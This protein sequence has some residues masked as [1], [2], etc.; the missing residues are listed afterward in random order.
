[1]NQR[2]N[3]FITFAFLG[4]S[5]ALLGGCI[6]TRT[7]SYPT[8][9]YNTV[10]KSA[11]AGVCSDKRLL[12]YEADKAKGVIMVQGR[13]IF[14]NL[15]ETPIVITGSGGG[16]SAK[17]TSTKKYRK[18]NAGT[19]GSGGGGT[20][21]VSITV[22]GMNNPWPDRMIGLISDNLPSERTAPAVSAP[23]DDGQN[24]DLEKQK[25]D[26]E[27]EKLKFEKEKLEFEKQKQKR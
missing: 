23:S 25:L 1:M 21:T 24:L 16:A 4:F 22:P 18:T 15:P 20:P 19:A 27:K 12:V 8:Q 5:A 13:G 9:N 3:N 6:T 2:N 7:A 17:N 14:T 10:F 11:V 26:L